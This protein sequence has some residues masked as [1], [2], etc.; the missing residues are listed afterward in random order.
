MQ[1]MLVDSSYSPVFLCYFLRHSQNPKEVPLISYPVRPKQV[2]M[3]PLSMQRDGLSYWL[4]E[5]GSPA[6]IPQGVVNMNRVLEVSQAEDVTGNQFSLAITAPDRVTFI[7]GTCREE[8]RWWMDVLSVFPRT[9]KQQGRHKRNATF[10]GIKSTTVLKQNMVHQYPSATLAPTTFET[11]MG[12][13]VRFHSCTSDPLVGRP[14]SAPA[15]DIDEDVFPTKDSSASSTPIPPSTQT[16]TPLYHSTPLSS[17]PPSTQILR[18]EH[19]E[20][21]PPYSEDYIDNP[22]TSES[23]PTQDKLS[24]KFR[25]R[26]AI[27]REA[28]GLMQPR[29]KSEMSALLPANLPPS[30]LLSPL[31]R[32]L[33][34]PTTARN[35]TTA[36]PS[37]SSSAKTTTSLSSF[38]SSLVNS[39][40]SSYS[41]PDCSR[42]H[43]SPVPSVVDPLSSYE[44]RP[45]RRATIA[46]TSSLSSLSS[47]NASLTSST[48]GINSSLSSSVGGNTNGGEGGSG[49]LSSLRSLDSGVHVPTRPHPRTAPDKPGVCVW[50]TNTFNF[51]TRYFFTI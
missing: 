38:S 34:A 27:K 15:L 28:R 33:P 4:W 44:G 26:R 30:A 42:S 9:H 10:P 24:H 35:T 12:Q 3:D 37:Y 51:L 23:P 19:K 2:L 13:R 32:G 45:I 25:T 47:I 8:S 39:S 5:T 40:T 16:P 41:T 11:S 36:T 50:I 49:G 6:T 48:L 18:D 14:P 7:K 43:L 17:L 20:N 46:L 22:P 1:D 31:S 29:S 21:T